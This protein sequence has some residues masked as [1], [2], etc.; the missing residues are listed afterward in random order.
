VI[1]PW[2]SGS[3]FCPQTLLI[4]GGKT[5][6]PAPHRDRLRAQKTAANQVNLAAA[7]MRQCCMHLRQRCLAQ[8]PRAALV[9]AL[10][11]TRPVVTLPCC[12]SGNILILFLF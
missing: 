7:E 5:P 8:R 1:A 12:C 3:A 4:D 11:A 9:D 10:Q 6:L 2:Q